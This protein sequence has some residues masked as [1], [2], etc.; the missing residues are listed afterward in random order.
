VGWRDLISQRWEELKSIVTNEVAYAG[1]VIDDKIETGKEIVG[2]V[3]SVVTN[4]AAY[5]GKVIDNKIETGKE[6]VGE[7]KSVVTNEADYA[8]KVIGNKIETGKEI[9][10]EVRNVVTNEA[11]YVGEVVGNTIETG[12]EYIKEAPA[13]IKDKATSIGNRFGDTMEKGRAYVN[14]TILNNPTVKNWAENLRNPSLPGDGL[15][16][17]DNLFTSGLG[18]SK[19][20]VELYVGGE[21]KDWKIDVSVVN[22]RDIGVNST[23]VSVIKDYVPDDWLDAWDFASTQVIQTP[24]PPQVKLAAQISKAGATGAKFLRKVGKS[25]SKAEKTADVVKESSNAGKDFVGTLKGQSVKLPG[26]KTEVINYT[27]RNPA[28]TAEL[29]KLFDSTERKKF[30]Q[31]LSEDTERLKKAGLSDA[32]IARMGNGQNPRNWQ[33]HH[34]VPLDAGGTNAMDNLVLIE[35][36][37]YHKVITNFQITSTKGLLSGETKI[38]EWP[39]PEGNIYPP[40]H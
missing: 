18:F 32:D 16:D 20:S 34:K 26:V 3:K 9:V 31:G 10:G 8:G 22:D 17:L 28:E 7:V 11:A 27:K 37:P 1:K 2:E 35:N 21:K 38:L 40:G 39:I 33:V 4:E 30:L 36:D 12:K 25:L 13:V 19:P 5:V 29:R 14:D 23:A 6:I 24:S 15:K